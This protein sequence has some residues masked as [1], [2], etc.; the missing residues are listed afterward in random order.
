MVKPMLRT[1]SLKR[2]K[3]KTPG[4]RSVTH[5]KKEKPGVA[6]CA[7]CKKPLHGVPRLN[8]LEMKKLPKTKKRPERP[9]GGNLCSKCMRGLFRRTAREI[10]GKK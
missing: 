6:K 4:K 7:I 1:K 2:K 8:P 10:L 3:V 9:Y 5:Y